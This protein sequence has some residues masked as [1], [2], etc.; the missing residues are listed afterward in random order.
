MI[1]IEQF[2]GDEA[3]A[4]GMYQVYQQLFPE[5]AVQDDDKQKHRP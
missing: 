4:K 2:R 5:L 1:M 3:R